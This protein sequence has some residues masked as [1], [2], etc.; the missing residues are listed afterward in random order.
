MVTEQP[1]VR[2]GRDDMTI[3]ILHMHGTIP[4]DPEGSDA[5][6]IQSFAGH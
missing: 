1:M 5:R 6:T 4:L 3:L 2:S